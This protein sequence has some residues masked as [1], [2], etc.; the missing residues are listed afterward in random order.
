[1]LFIRSTEGNWKQMLYFYTLRNFIIAVQFT[2]WNV[3]NRN[4]CLC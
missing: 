3:W 2:L 4:G 1:M